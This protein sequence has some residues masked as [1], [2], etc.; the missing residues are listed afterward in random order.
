MISTVVRQKGESQNGC[1]KKTKHA[2]FS[3]KRTFLTESFSFLGKFVMLCFFKTLVLRFALLLYYRRYMVSIFSEPLATFILC[4]FENR[5]LLV[6][7]NYGQMSNKCRILS[8][9]LV[10]ER[11]AAVRG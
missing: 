11:R 1:F 3:E 10:R 6:T 8:A 4:L 5:F 9:A 2:K 7:L